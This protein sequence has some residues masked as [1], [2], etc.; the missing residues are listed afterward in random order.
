MREY[1]FVVARR[2]RRFPGAV[3]AMAGSSML[4]L[5]F[6]LPWVV[7]RDIVPGVSPALVGYELPGF[8]RSS[9]FLLA[10]AMGR[11]LDVAPA[12]AN[13]VWLVPVMAALNLAAG[14]LA[15]LS[16]K[17]RLVAGLVHVTTA[18]LLLGVAAYVLLR[19]LAVT[20]MSVSTLLPFAG[21][22]LWLSLAGL[23][24]ILVGG[25]VELAGR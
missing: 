4:L 20:T 12:L 11:E 5:G 17:G 2:V 14:P 13:A 22:G 25:I 23:L 21:A 1:S 19:I 15:L 7:F 9:S 24:L 3:L 18:M 10:L 6:V 8:V 16:R